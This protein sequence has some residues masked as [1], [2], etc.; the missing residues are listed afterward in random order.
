[1]ASAVPGSGC[2]APR[3]PSRSDF[4][5]SRSQNLDLGL[6]TRRRDAA[7]GPSTLVRR[8]GWVGSILRADSAPCTVRPDERR[9]MVRGGLSSCHRLLESDWVVSVRDRPPR[10][11][12]EK[13]V[14]LNLPRR[15]AFILLRLRF[16]STLFLSLPD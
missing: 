4:P 8:H 11:F 14:K 9:H 16:V 6:R 10:A 5:C 2:S 12:V 13:I 3:D 15:I 7:F 1:M